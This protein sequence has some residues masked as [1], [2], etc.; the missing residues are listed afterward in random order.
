MIDRSDAAVEERRR[1]RLAEVVADRAEHDGELLGPR[2]IVDARARL[3]DDLQRVH[4]DV[5]FGMPLRFLRAADERVQLGK[6]LLDDAELERQREADRRPRREQQLLDFAPDALGRQIV[7]RN[8]RGTDSRVASSSV[9][10]EP[11]REL[12]APAARAGCRRR[13]SPD[14]RRAAGGGSRSPRPSNGSRYS[15]VSGSQEIALIVKSRRRA[16]SSIVIDGSPV[17]SKPRW[18]RPDFDSRRGS[19]TSMSPSL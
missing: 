9:E 5:A 19:D 11:R 6:Q 14:R 10:V 13:T 1:R 16:A 17:T 18:P 12:D 4:P 3:I 15:S 7:E 8:R 2:Q